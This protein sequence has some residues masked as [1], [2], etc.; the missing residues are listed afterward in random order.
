MSRQRIKQGECSECGNKVLVRDS[1]TGEIVCDFCGLVI[2]KE[3][4]S[5]KQEWT[6][7]TP[8]EY[9]KRTRTAILYPETATLIGSYDGQVVSYEVK[10]LRKYQRQSSSRSTKER[11]WTNA[12]RELERIIDRLHLPSNVKELAT[13]IYKMALNQDLIRGRTINGFVTASIHF[14]CRLLK[15][16]RSLEELEQI[17]T[18][19]KKEIARIYRFL[20]RE[21]ANKLNKK[22]GIKL[23]IPNYLQTTEKISKKLDLSIETEQL[24][25]KIV[26]IAKKNKITQGRS[27]EGIAAAALY[28][29]CRLCGEKRI[30]KEIADKAETTEVTLRNR[31]K[32]LIEKLVFETSL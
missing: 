32:E 22:L 6:A 27:P 30:Q 2:K 25:I 1:K 16:S 23:K 8:Q 18:F 21:L 5:R 19:S 24:A 28:I 7:F 11:N 14:A 20:H 13:V 31:Y 4:I 9:Y 26:R 29:A 10:R 17:T 3:K 15:V 12:G